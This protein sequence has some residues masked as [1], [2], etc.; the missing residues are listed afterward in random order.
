METIRKIFCQI[1]LVM[2]AI[3]FCRA[4]DPLPI[5]N[6]VVLKYAQEHLGK[7]VGDGICF[8]LVDKALCQASPEWKRREY[9]R[10]FW[11]KSEYAYGE[12][13]KAPEIIPGDIVCYKWKYRSRKHVYSH[14]AIIYSVTE[15]GVQVLEQNA[16]GSVWKSRV[17]MNPLFVVSDDAIKVWEVKYYR[18]Y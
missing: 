14:V 15:K 17:R 11:G 2:L 4:T 9:Y 1:V 8:T 6:R 16:D 13:I 3:I 7:K 5:V 10:S 18:P 12:K